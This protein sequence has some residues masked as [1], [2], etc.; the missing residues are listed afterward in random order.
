[1][2]A[3]LIELLNP[4]VACSLH[5]MMGRLGSTC[6]LCEE[7]LRQRFRIVVLTI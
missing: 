4:A 1:V 2:G 5:S 7:S 6:W 3:G